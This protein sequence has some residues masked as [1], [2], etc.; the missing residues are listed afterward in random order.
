MPDTGDDTNRPK[1]RIRN[2][3]E[4]YTGPYLVI[5]E[6]S[7]GNI[8]ASKIAKMLIQKFDRDY[9]R[10]IPMTKKKMKILMRSRQAANQ[11]V[12]MEQENIKFSIPQRLIECLGV[13]YIEPEIDS[14]ELN[15]AVAFDKAKL[16]QDGNPAVVETRRITKKANDGSTKLLYTVIITFDGLTLPSHVEINQVLYG[17]NPYVYPTRQ[18]TNCWRLGHDRKN[19][20][21][22]IRCPSCLEGNIDSDHNCGQETPQCVNCHGDH[23]ANDH[24]RCQKIIAKKQEDAERQSTYSQGRTDWFCTLAPEEADSNVMQNN[25]QNTQHAEVHSDPRAS[26]TNNLATTSAPPPKRRLRDTDCDDEL[27]QLEVHIS[28]GVCKSIQSGIESNEVVEVMAE[29]LEVAPEDQESRAKI[30]EH[31]LGRITELVNDR[32]KKYLDTLRL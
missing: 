19:C 12:I 32:V 6:S 21:S 18:C 22:A 26:A 31:V 1:R 25:V 2:Y 17:V 16:I 14:D 24:R 4:A 13:A 3:N 28:D 8:V 29:V 11:L 10:S 20:K 7:N 30:R 27:P 15:T 23:K 9:V 5:A